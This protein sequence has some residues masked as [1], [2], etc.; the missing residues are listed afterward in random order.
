MRIL[1][2][3]SAPGVGAEAAASLTAEG[4]ELVR[5]IDPGA[6][7]FPCREVEEPGSCPLGTQPAVDCAVV[8]HEG[9]A[10]QPTAWEAGVSCALRHQVPVVTRHEGAKSPFAGWA[11][12]VGDAGIDAACELAVTAAR[13]HEVRPL[14]DEVE[15]FLDR[16]G[17]APGGVAVDIRREGDRARIVVTV[18]PGGGEHAHAI[19]TRVHARYGQSRRPD[20]GSVTDIEVREA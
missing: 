9:D 14:V 19:A 11:I 1:L 10:R 18:P 20:A 6:P 16:L 4:H 8:V 13:A 2:L 7:A 5:C 12:P 3:E 15:Q 17:I